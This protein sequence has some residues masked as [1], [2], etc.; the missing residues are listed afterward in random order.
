MGFHIVFNE[1]ASAHDSLA[2]Q[3]SNVQRYGP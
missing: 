3:K 1:V 2:Y